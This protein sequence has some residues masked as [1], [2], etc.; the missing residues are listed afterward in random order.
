M[1][2]QCVGEKDKKLLLSKRKEKKEKEDKMLHIRC[3]THLTFTSCFM[4]YT[5]L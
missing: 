5:T 4:S 1:N 3:Y 2:I